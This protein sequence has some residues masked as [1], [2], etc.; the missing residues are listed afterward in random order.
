MVYDFFD[1]ELFC[2]RSLVF[3][4]LLASCNVF[5][6]NLAGFLLLELIVLSNRFVAIILWHVS[7]DVTEV[8]LF[9]C[10][11]VRND[12]LYGHWACGF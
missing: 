7:S 11:E 4:V 6:W 10:G 3:F 2:V 12:F 1:R 9:R 8:V 5:F